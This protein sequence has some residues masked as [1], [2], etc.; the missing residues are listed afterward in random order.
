[1]LETADSKA[2]TTK[3][4]SALGA[5]DTLELVESSKEVIRQGSK[6][7]SFA[8]MFFE[9][10]EKEGAWLLYSWCRLCDDAVDQA[11][12]QASALRKLDWLEEQTRLA[13]TTE[14]HLI[15]PAF[16]GLRVLKK[17]YLLPIELPLDLLSGMRMDVEGF[18]PQTFDDLVKYCYHVAGVVG[19]MMCHIMD[20]R[21][22]KA[23]MHAIAFGNALQ[24]TNIIRDV[25]EDWNMG[26]IYIPLEWITEIGIDADRFQEHLPQWPLLIAKLSEAADKRYQ[27]GREGLHFLPWRC[28]LACRIAGTVYQRIGITALQLG[29]RAW[30][31]RIVVPLPTKI[32]MA[33]K[34]I[35]AQAKET[36]LQIL[37][38]N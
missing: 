23:H 32:G 28:R 26:R 21:S 12:S 13:L 2:I 25:K 37:R 9:Q 5:R 10:R 19:L 6:S 29:P 7:F 22:E 8:S 27:F 17:D 15:H 18:R 31:Q 34:E 30:N 35:F 36:L 11:E 16:E 33:M 38:L 1:M 20:V 4:S 24:M 14:D 3:N